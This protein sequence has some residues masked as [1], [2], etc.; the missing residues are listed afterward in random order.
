MIHPYDFVKAVVS[1]DHASDRLA[2]ARLGLN[3]LYDA[4]AFPFDL[5]EIKRM[6]TN[7]S[8]LAYGLIIH[9]T[10]RPIFYSQQSASLCEEL[11]GLTINNKQTAP[12]GRHDS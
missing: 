6:K 10:G 11:I 7:A 3:V 8:L 2:L 1:H 12:G 9:A 5:S 4:D